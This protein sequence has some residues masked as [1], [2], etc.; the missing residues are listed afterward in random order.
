MAFV[1]DPSLMQ[2]VYKAAASA[3]VGGIVAMILWP[4]RKMKKEWAV[5]K[6]EQGSIH[7]ELVT[8]RN[9]CLASLQRQGET[10]IELLGKVADTLT[11][12]ALSQA[13]MTGYCKANTGCGP[14]LRRRRT[15]K[16]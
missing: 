10:Q 4:F 3:V 8:Q 12:M 9:N 11:G 15:A 6:A 13:E 7:T 16:K 14:M 1:A 2:Y 5:M